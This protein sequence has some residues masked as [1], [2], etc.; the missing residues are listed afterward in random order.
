MIVGL[1]GQKRVGKDTAALALLQDGFYVVKFADGLKIMLRALLKSLDYSDRGI[2]SL[3]E[4]Q[5]KEVPLPVLAGRSPRYAMQTL[6]TE[7]GRNCMGENIWVEIA[8][9]RCL[10]RKNSVITDCRFPN[11]AEAIHRAGGVLIRITRDTHYTDTH[12]SEALVDSLPFDYEVLNTGTIENLGDEV[13]Q[14]V[15]GHAK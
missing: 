4:N 3:L 12:S 8:I 13:R 7:W 9:E 10:G 14:I 6:G 1:I 2:D 5:L 15:A 11:E